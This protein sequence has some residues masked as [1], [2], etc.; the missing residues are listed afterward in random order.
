MKI[1][2]SHVHFWDPNNLSY[3]WTKGNATLDRA[4]LPEDF[5]TANGEHTVEGIVFVEAGCD[6]HL[7]I[8]EVDW[9]ETLDAPIKAIVANSPLDSAYGVEETL[10]NLASRPLVKGIR[11]IYQDQ[12][13]GFARDSAFIKAVRDLK[14][15]DLSFDICIKSYQLDETI[16]LVEKSPDIQFILDHIA[17]PRIADGEF[18]YWATRMKK[19]A[20]LENVSCKI[21]GIIT[22]A[23]HSNWTQ[24]QIKPYILHTIEAFGIDRVMFGSDWP[25]VNLAGSY[26]KWVD[27]LTY[28]TGDLSDDEKQKL[29]IDN[30]TRFYRLD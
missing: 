1:I 9:I 26:T 22:E 2:D 25:V 23:D 18:D 20:G 13:E 29:F 3:S 6:S 4:Y 24:E 12:P 21:S 30:V 10:E 16:E 15:Y 8:E 7:H 14:K 28:A 5:K 11:R 27:T 17:K 19:L